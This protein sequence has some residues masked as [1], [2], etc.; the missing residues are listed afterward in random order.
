MLF[1]TRIK[2]QTV[3]WNRTNDDPQDL[4]RVFI[5]DTEQIGFIEYAAKKGGEKEWFVDWEQ[6]GGS[7]KTHIDATDRI[8]S[9]NLRD[10]WFLNQIINAAFET[11]EVIVNGSLEGHLAMRTSINNMFEVGYVPGIVPPV[12]FPSSTA[13]GSYLEALRDGLI[14]QGFSISKENPLTFSQNNI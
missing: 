8:L 14:T 3:K 7:F 6:S 1:Q 9:Y 10:Q 4:Y 11:W 12:I 13:I 2:N 5:N